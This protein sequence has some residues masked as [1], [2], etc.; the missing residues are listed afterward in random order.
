MSRRR[1]PVAAADEWRRRDMAG[2]GGMARLV[3]VIDDDRAIGELYRAI[4][5]DEGY[6]V[7]VHASP[8]LALAAVVELRPDLLVLDLRFGPDGRGADVVAR[9]KGDPA[10]RA[11]PVLV[12][13]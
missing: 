9:L 12:C 3:L 6:R 11:L 1:R 13:S 7:R 4:L 10:T 8:D 5:E 2:G